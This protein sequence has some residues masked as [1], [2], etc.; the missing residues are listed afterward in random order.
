M[1]DNRTG[2]IVEGGAEACFQPGLETEITVPNH[3]LEK[4]ID[5]TDNRGRSDKLRAEFGAL[6]NTARDN[7]RNGRGKCQQEEKLDQRQALRTIGLA[8]L[9]AANGRG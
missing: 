1:H 9:I 4:R 5:K 6:G 2:K 7:R 3:A 8:A